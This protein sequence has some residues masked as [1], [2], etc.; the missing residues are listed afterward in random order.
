MLFLSLRGCTKEQYDEKV[1]LLGGILQMSQTGGKSSTEKANILADKHKTDKAKG[2][3]VREAAMSTQ[4]K[5]KGTSVI[6]G[7][8][9]LSSYYL[10]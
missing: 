10:L 7:F 8:A 1:T 3:S 2:E 6:F 9:V 4:T 5:R